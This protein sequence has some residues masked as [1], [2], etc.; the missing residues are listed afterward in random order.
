MKTKHFLTIAVI[1]FVSTMI[2]VSCSKNGL[3]DSAALS[4]AVTITKPEIKKFSRSFDTASTAVAYKS[5][6]IN[7]KVAATILKFHVR[8]GD[9]VK[10]G[11]LLAK[12]DDSDYAVG[13]Q[14]SRAQLEAAEAGVMQAE[15]AYSKISADYERFQTL[16]ESGSI[17]A[18]D[19]EQVESGY[20][21]TAAGLAAAKAQRNMAAAALEGNQRQ[22]NYT[23]IIAPFSG[24]VASRNGEIGEMASP[25][26]PRPMFEIV[27]S[28]KLKVNIFISELEIGS[29]TK[30]TVA[31]ITFD[32]F[33]EDPVEAKVNLINSKVDPMTK[34]VKIELAVDNS[35][36]KFKP[37]MTVRV[38]F[39]FPE[40]EYLVIP[41]NAV[42]TRD[43]EAGVVY[44][45]NE[46]ERVFTK[47]I[48]MGGNVEGY[49]IIESGLDGKEDI[50]VGGGRRLEEG[51]KVTVIESQDLKK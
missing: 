39:T 35:A 26:S 20:K 48:F 21:Q 2:S 30:E 1:I 15:A 34:S 40:K 3:D 41:R 38:N 5:A 22:L 10:E 9:A 50:V 36:M 29:I 24:F 32:A 14:A 45:K 28:D 7:P 16:K 46:A 27:Q 33:P 43:N 13:V 18:S 31:K 44:V 47:E 17:S 37:G 6:Y 49:V 51:Q 42:F 4:Q 23:S 19:Y 11:Q 25:A 8:E 12:L